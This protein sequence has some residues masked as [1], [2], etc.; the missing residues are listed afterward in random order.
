MD[1]NELKPVK[2]DEGSV[3][4]LRHPATEELIPG[5]TITLMGQDSAT[6]RNLQLAKQKAALER[7]SKG[8]AAIETN[9]AKL[10]ED[11]IE[12]LVKLTLGWTGFT[13]EGKELKPTPE[14]I[15]K[16]YTEWQW[17]KEQAQ[18]FISG[19]ANFFR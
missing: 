5:M 18:E 19:R 17:I 12:D 15:R 8:K 3:M 4:E 9:P 7:V 16:V 6:Y 13:L 1:L 11:T 2:A 10:A 14:N